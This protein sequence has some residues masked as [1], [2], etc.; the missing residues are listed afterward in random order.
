[1]AAARP[2]RGTAGP[3]A[4]VGMASA[5]PLGPWHLDPVGYRLVN[6]VEDVE[7]SLPPLGDCRRLWAVA[8]EGAATYG[9]ECGALVEALASVF[10][11]PAV[12]ARPSLVPER[13]VRLWVEL[14][15]QGRRPSGAVRSHYIRRPGD[16]AAEVRALLGGGR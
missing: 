12:V 5:G 7:L 1:M 15:A 13:E 8:C 11:V 16:V 3:A 9:A 2:G 6:V 14:L 4:A 10:T